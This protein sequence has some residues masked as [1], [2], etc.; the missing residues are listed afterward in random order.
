MTMSRIRPKVSFAIFKSAL[1]CLRGSSRRRRELLTS[2]DTDFEVE[3]ARS[4]Y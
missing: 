2:Q 1:L 3:V 4:R